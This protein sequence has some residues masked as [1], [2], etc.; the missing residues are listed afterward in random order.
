M[1]QSNKN[2]LY[3]YE[4]VMI[5]V[6][7]VPKQSF[8]LLKDHFQHDQEKNVGNVASQQ[9]VKC[10]LVAVSV[11]V[12]QRS[13]V[14]SVFVLQDSDVSVFEVK[15]IVCVLIVGRQKGAQVSGRERE[16]RYLQCQGYSSNLSLSS[17]LWEKNNNKKTAQTKNKQQQQHIIF[18]NFH[19]N[20]VKHHPSGSLHPYQFTIQVDRVKNCRFQ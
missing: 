11:F 3:F 6:L 15:R 14:L 16:L 19:P 4:K 1:R 10:A 18:R 9:L 13:S 12:L 2:S 20:S 5:C 7:T 17:I 8:Q